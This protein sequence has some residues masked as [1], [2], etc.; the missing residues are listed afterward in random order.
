YRIQFSISLDGPAGTNDRFRITRSGQGTAAKVEAAIGAIFEHPAARYFQG[1]LAVADPGSSGAEVYRYFRRLGLR[2]IDFL[3]PDGNYAAP[4][5]HLEA[6][7]RGPGEFLVEAF[8]AWF[9]EDDPAVQVRSFVEIIRGAL[10]ERP[11]VDHFGRIDGS[12]AFIETDGGLIAHD[13]LRICGPPHDRSKLNVARDPIGALQRPEFFPW[14]EPAP[15]CAEC[16]LFRICGGGYPPHRFDG[17]SFD[18]PSYYCRDLMLLIRHIA[19]R[20]SEVSP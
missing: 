15:Q 19:G 10:G 7:G 14:S 3:L 12:I 2:A 5:F 11:T 8:D 4:P 17:R 13:V 6:T 1:V 18:N 20:V 16:S 9:E